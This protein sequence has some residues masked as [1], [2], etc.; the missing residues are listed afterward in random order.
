MIEFDK[1]YFIIESSDIEKG[2][3]GR[4]AVGKST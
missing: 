3:R 1:G 4:G 2:I